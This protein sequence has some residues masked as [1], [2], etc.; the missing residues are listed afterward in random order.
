VAE[1]PAP[2][3]HPGGEA[4]PPLR[5]HGHYRP[6]RPL[7]RPIF[8]RHNLAPPP[9]GRGRAS[10]RSGEVVDQPMAPQ[11]PSASRWCAI[12]AS[13]GRPRTRLQAGWGR[14]RGRRGPGSGS[15]SVRSQAWSVSHASWSRS[16]CRQRA[17]LSATTRRARPRR[18]LPPCNKPFLVFMISGSF[19]CGAVCGA[20]PWPRAM[21]AL[22]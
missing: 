11:K 5:R 6:G 17:P 13:V 9:R 4:R 8:V 2:D 22:L 3:R 7:C 1:A 21:Q 20:R 14:Q 10:P 15:A 12:P 19:Q 16:G 18:S